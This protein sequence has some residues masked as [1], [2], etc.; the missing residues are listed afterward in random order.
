MCVIANHFEN[1][2][3]LLKNIMMW[4]MEKSCSEVICA[5]VWITLSFLGCHAAK[6]NVRLTL[7]K[8]RANRCPGDRVGFAPPPS[9]GGRL[10]CFC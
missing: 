7:I 10:V 2:V 5:P 3:F 4:L 1:I 9:Q 8:A 6:R